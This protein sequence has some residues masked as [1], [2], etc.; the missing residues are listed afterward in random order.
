[1]FAISCFGLVWWTREYVPETAG[2]SLEEVDELFKSEA[3]REDAELR[4]E[5]SFI[6]VE[7]IDAQTV[8]SVPLVSDH[9]R[10]G[11]GVAD[12]RTVCRGKRKRCLS[13]FLVFWFLLSCFIWSFVK[14]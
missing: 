12:S 7:E 8:E 13:R 10:G 3:G 6:F 2:V 4:R 14:G 5:V 9:T 11:P 1:M